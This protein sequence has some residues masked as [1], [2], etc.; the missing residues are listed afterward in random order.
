MPHTKMS[1]NHA[2]TLRQNYVAFVQ[3]LQA[4]KLLPYFIQDGVISS[5]QQQIILS[6]HSCQARNRQLH[7]Y[8]N[9]KG[10]MGYFSLIHALVQQQGNYINLA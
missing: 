4:E 6:K 7:Y 10:D 9:K 2:N 1:E 8:I 5:E 3:C